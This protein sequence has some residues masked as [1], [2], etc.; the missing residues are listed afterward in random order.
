[1]PA[2][3]PSSIA[4]C[5]VSSIC[6]GTRGIDP[7]GDEWL[8]LCDAD[9]VRRLAFQQVAALPEARGALVDQARPSNRSVSIGDPGSVSGHTIVYHSRRTRRSH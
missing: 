8:V 6:R 3:S 4:R 5:S 9:G 7:D 1:M 2:A